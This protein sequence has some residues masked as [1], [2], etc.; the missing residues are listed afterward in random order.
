MAAGHC[1]ACPGPRRASESCAA[2]AC[3]G[4]RSRSLRPQL[5]DHCQRSLDQHP[6]PFWS[7][8]VA[9]D[10]GAIGSA[11][12]AANGWQIGARSGELD[13]ERLQRRAAGLHLHAVIGVELKRVGGD[14]HVAE[15]QQV[16]FR[17][18]DVPRFLP[19]EAIDDNLIPLPNSLRGSIAGKFSHFGLRG[20]RFLLGHLPHRQFERFNPMD[21]RGIGM[22]FFYRAGVGLLPG[23]DDSAGDFLQSVEPAQDCA[24]VLRPRCET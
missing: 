9:L 22:F 5:A 15:P 6:A 8:R 13:D 10:H 16:N 12:R 20:E 14:R 7:D 19:L 24:S 4:E 18:I 2:G 11:G 23:R 21:Q 3:R 1:T 17:P